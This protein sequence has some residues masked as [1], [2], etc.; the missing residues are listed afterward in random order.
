MQ[1]PSFWLDQPSR[2]LR[3]IRLLWVLATTG[4]L[5]RPMFASY[6]GEPFN[7]GAQSL[8][9]WASFLVKAAVPASGVILE[10]LGSK[11]AKWVNVGFWALA[12][13]YYCA[14][15]AYYLSDAYFGVLLIMGVGL[16]IHAGINFLL[17]R[18]RDRQLK[19]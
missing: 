8:E 13:L 19:T 3:I 16:L 7:R 5:V 18:G 4:L 6:F 1:Q 15:A 14:G 9:L 10:I 17:Y 2:A 11:Y 12:G